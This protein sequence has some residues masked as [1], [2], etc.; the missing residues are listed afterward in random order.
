MQKYFRNTENN[1]NIISIISGNFEINMKEIIDLKAEVSD[2]K[3]RLQ[4]AENIIE[5][6]VAT[7][8]TELEYLK[9]KVHKNQ[10]L[11]DKFQLYLT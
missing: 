11:P 8:E 10:R 2:I 3:D 7:L 6:K 5:K 1:I 4:F 9:D